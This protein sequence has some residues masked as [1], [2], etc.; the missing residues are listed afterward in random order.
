[1]D[2]KAFRKYNKISQ[3][4]LADYLGVGQSFISQIERG[5]SSI[6]Q[7]MIEKI[8]SNPDWEIIEDV[9]DPVGRK[10]PL[11]YDAPT[12]G[13]MNDMVAIVGDASRSVK[14]VNPGDWFPDATSAIQ[15]FGDSM[16]EY[17]SGS[18]LVLR[19]VNDPRLLIN[20]EIYVIETDEFRITKQ[21]Q[22]DGGDYIVAYSSN[23][24]TYPDGHLIHSPIRIPKDSI[25]HL[26]LVLGCIIKRFSSGLVPLSTD[27]TR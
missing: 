17:P 6:P 22:D 14:M 9:E 18:L 11:Y 25:R 21:I 20:G 23:T 19:R 16:V 2:L 13:G 1:M 3:Q 8:R 12:I 7:T 26:D 24:D 27:R 15:H 5:A 10:I 4:E